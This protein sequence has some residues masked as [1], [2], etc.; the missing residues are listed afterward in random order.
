MWHV[1]ELCPPYIAG[2][3]NVS[4]CLDCPN[5]LESLLDA[6]PNMILSNCR[7]EEVYLID[8]NPLVVPILI[9]AALTDSMPHSYTLV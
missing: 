2:A 4:Y 8:C 6:L 3:H 5:L 7:N 1:C 9:A